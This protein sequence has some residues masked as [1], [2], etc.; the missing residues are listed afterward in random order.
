MRSADSPVLGSPTLTVI[1]PVFNEAGTVA[2][3]LAQLVGELT[4]DHEILVVD[5]GSND[6]TPVVLEKWVGTPGIA[7]LRHRENRGKGAAIRTGLAQAHGRFT[8]IQDADLEYDPRGIADVVAP[9]R[10]GEADVVYGS[11]YLAPGVPLPWSKFRLAVV[12]LN[13]LVRVLYGRWFTDVAT[14][15]KAF[16]TALL[17]ALDLQASRFEIC[18]EMTAKTCRLGLRIVEVPIIYAPRSKAEGKK[19]GWRDAW[20]AA[21]TL[22]RWRCGPQ[23]WGRDWRPDEAEPPVNAPCS[24]PGEPESV[25]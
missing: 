4:I 2:R 11:R 21:W 12:L 3:I 13:A 10:R 23:T 24:V 9:L 16:P 7:V 17:R 18:P 6:A 1:V 25:I 8:I 20:E 19:I 14:C 5:D 15:Y 22:L